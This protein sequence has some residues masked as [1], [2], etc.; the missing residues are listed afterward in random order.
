MCETSPSNYGFQNQRD[1]K[2][3][4]HHLGWFMAPE[5]WYT[6]GKPNTETS[7]QSHLRR[8][9][10]LQ[11]VN[12]FLDAVIAYWVWN[13]KEDKDLFKDGV[14]KSRFKVVLKELTVEDPESRSTLAKAVSDLIGPLYNFLILDCCYR[15]EILNYNV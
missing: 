15:N 9:L 6:Y 1:L 14:K 7:L 12:A 5:L 13:N 8:H 10:Y 11:V 2:A 3:F 4:H